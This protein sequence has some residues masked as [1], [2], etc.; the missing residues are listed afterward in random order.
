MLIISNVGCP[1]IIY[2]WALQWI[3]IILQIWKCS[4]QTMLPTHLQNFGCECQIITICQILV[5]K[6]SLFKI[7]ITKHRRGFVLHSSLYGLSLPLSLVLGRARPRVTRSPTEL[8]EEMKTL[9]DTFWKWGQIAFGR[10]CLQSCWKSDLCHI[11]HICKIH[12]QICHR[13]KCT[14]S[15]FQYFTGKG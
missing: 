7:K 15:L 12:F 14:C 6:I 4:T 3:F 2:N 9:I 1:W 13:S 10:K 11:Y 8:G 5:D